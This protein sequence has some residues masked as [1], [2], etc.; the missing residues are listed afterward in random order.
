[1]RRSTQQWPNQAINTEALRTG[2]P[3]IG[4]RLSRRSPPM[5]NGWAPRADA[6]FA[7]QAGRFSFV[8]R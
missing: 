7:N 2:S 1:M 6:D 4:L 8:G 5:L 3:D